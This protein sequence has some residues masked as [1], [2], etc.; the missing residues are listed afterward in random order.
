[1]NYLYVYLIAIMIIMTL[2]LRRYF[3]KHAQDVAALEVAVQSGLAEP[4]SLHPI[5]DPSRCMGSGACAK[6]CPE[7][8]LGVINGKMALTNAAACIGH[9]ACLAACPTEAITLVF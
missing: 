3:R 7:E 2:Y 1:M 4:A 5:V 6:S 8:A 9:G